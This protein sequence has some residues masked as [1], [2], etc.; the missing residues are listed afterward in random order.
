ME[1]EVVKEQLFRIE[2]WT[3][4]NLDVGI[5]V[6]VAYKYYNPSEH[7][8][9]CKKCSKGFLFDEIILKNVHCCLLEQKNVAIHRENR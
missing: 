8:G 3:S 4:E 6:I 2:N 5:T 9:Q 1:K 7:F